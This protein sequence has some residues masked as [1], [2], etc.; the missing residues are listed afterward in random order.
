MTFTFSVVMAAYNA[1]KYIMESLN[2]II[3]QSI[4]FNDN[5]QIIIVND[6]SK[7]NTKSICESYV[8][9]YPD[10]IKLINNEINKGPAYTRNRGL[11]EVE[12]KYVN[13][14]DSDDYISKNTFEKVF[15]FFED[16][17]TIDIVSIP[18]HFFGYKR[19][20]HPLNYKFKRNGIVNLKE[21][22]NYIQL[23]AASSFFRYSKL[24]SKNFNENLTVSEDALLINQ[25]LLENPKYAVLSDCEYHYRKNDFENSLISN[26]ANNKSY[27]TT[28]IDNYFFRLI[29]DSLKIYNEVP[30]FIQNV[31]MYDLQ[32][33]LEIRDISNLLSEDE[34]KELYEKIFS[35]LFYIGDEVILNQKSIPPIL[36]SHI[37]LL[38]YF[39]WDYLNTKT[40]NIQEI[41]EKFLEN[42]GNLVPRI[43]KTE[44]ASLIKQLSL[45]KVYIDNFEFKNPKELYIS[46][47]ITSLFNK[48]LNVLAVINDDEEI[49]ESIKLRFPQRDNY[50]LN[51]NYGFNHNFEVKIP[52]ND[53]TKV[54]FRAD[55]KNSGDSNSDLEILDEDLLIDYNLTSRLS[56]IS[57]FKLSKDYI[58]FDQGKSILVKKRGFADFISN[59]F[60]T[61]ASILKQRREGWRT[62]FV[63]RGLYLISYPF[64]KNKRIWILMDLPYSA[65][66]NGLQLFKY[67]NSLDDNEYD[68]FDIS[69]GELNDLRKIKVYFTLEKSSSHYENML[70][71][72][73]EYIASSN[74]DKIKKL[75]GLD[76]PSKEY[77]EISRIGNILPYKSLKH[78]LYSMYA[79]LIVSSHPDNN[80]I[81]PFWGNYPHLAGLIKSKSVFLQ[82][83][84]TKD[85]VSSWLNIFDKNLD[86]LVTVS[87]SEKESFLSSNYGYDEDIIKVLGFPRFDYLESLEDKR[88]I[89]IMPT[90]RRQYHNF[91]DNEFRQSHFFKTF[92]KLINDDE[93]LDYLDENNYKLVF[94]PHPNLNKFI[95]LFDK[96]KRVDFDLND[97]NNDYQGYS[98]RRYTDIFNHSSLI[99]T[100]FSSVSFDFAYLKKPLI[101]Y[102]YDND[103][104]FDSENGYFSYDEMGFG[105]VVTDYDD[106]INNIK[107]YVDSDCRMEDIYKKRVDDFFK[108]MDKNNCKRVYKEL[109]ELNKYY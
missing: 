63:L 7:D 80:I 40:F 50:S 39:G 86:L 16:H 33:I 85:D 26:S 51:F 41:D 1:E 66:D 76:N 43:N 75:L 59:E 28:R 74:K 90:W 71:L 67:I 96:D 47:M 78:R 81:Y 2:S 38:K 20:S 101:Y 70:S 98:S 88:E 84:V 14:L 105:P 22:P 57:Q 103:Y 11:S 18:I 61:L 10:N 109:V 4:G 52:I 44:L 106:L 29:D 79:E 37:V 89:I 72:E 73:N 69:K 64:L 53:N 45:N 19:G 12:G 104:H 94:K 13:F 83:G 46:G 17:E 97:L 24:E 35:L 9:K 32:W 60:K 108:Y 56:R 15:N 42:D 99:V 100:D 54:S 102:H 107:S 36:K 65:D 48:E 30:E 27:F 91:R 87:E 34:I 62:G 31:I 5:I 3:K 21:N 55:L 6:A 93:L 8:E 49:I 68:K 82:H 95:K 77:G 23:S 58:S 25:L 92:N